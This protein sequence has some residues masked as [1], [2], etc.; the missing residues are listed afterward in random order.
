MPTL[1]EQLQAAVVQTTTDSSLLH[2][3]V[4]GDANTTVTTEGGPVKSIAKVIGENQTELAQSIVD[5]TTKRDETLVAASAA[6][7]ARLNAENSATEASGHRDAA[8]TAATNAAASNTSAAAH[9]TA[10][11]A[12]ELAAAQSQSAALTAK[13]AAETAANNAATSAANALTSENAA[14]AAAERLTATSVSSVSIGTG[15][16]TFTTQSGKMFSEG[17]WV[18][19]VSTAS[20]ANYMHG[21]VTSYSGTSLVVDV[22]N[23]GGSGTPTSWN[24]SV[25]GTRGATGASAAANTVTYTNTTSGLA[26]TNIQAA[27]DEL[28][29]RLDNLNTGN[30]SASGAL[31]I[32][33]IIS[34]AQL[35]ADT[36]DWNP[37]GLA[38]ASAIRVSTDAARTITGIAGGSA[39]RVLVLDNI[40]ASDITLKHQITSVTANRFICPGNSDFTLRVSTSVTLRYDGTSSRW[41][42][43]AQVASSS[44]HT[45]GYVRGLTVENNSSW[46]IAVNI[47][48]AEVVLTDGNGRTCKFNNLNMSG[49][50]PGGGGINPTSARYVF[51]GVGDV[52]LGG[53]MWV[54]GYLISDGAGNYAV[55]WSSN[56]HKPNITQM[57]ASGYPEYT[58]WSF[59][60][61]ITAQYIKPAGDNL[62]MFQ[63]DN[64]VQ[65]KQWLNI[66]NGP[67]GSISGPT[68]A[69]VGI[70]GAGYVAPPDAVTFRGVLYSNTGGTN[71][72]AAPNNSFGQFGSTSNGP[73]VGVNTPSGNGGTYVPFEFVLESTNIFWA[74][75]GSSDRLLS[76]GF[77]INL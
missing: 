10:A 74:A 15:S 76:R 22:T 46:N 64:I 73:V 55:V 30:L 44:S 20:A 32:S 62:P 68:W 54:Y 51:G 25:S 31:T 21:Q 29:T 13:S 40:G 6:A 36:H 4:H 16:K 59:Y 77:T 27:V 43:M 53:G 65:W 67:A 42:I 72:M 66:A 52:S 70:L 35:T 71:C 9:R 39:G 75:Q 61:L 23:T 12:S 19:A 50:S 18:L 63:R 24:I 37:T 47:T 56:Y 2:T 60:K 3:I 45:Q 57:V 8:Q 33:G 49:G 26:A 14:N 5:V 7:T 38:S 48:I 11:E 41:R 28:D 58:G 34:P 17:T 1:Q 69:A